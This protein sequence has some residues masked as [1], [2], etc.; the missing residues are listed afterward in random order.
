[1][2]QEHWDVQTPNGCEDNILSIGKDSGAKHKR[3]KLEKTVLIFRPGFYFSKKERQ[4]LFVWLK[5]IPSVVDI[6]ECEGKVF[7]DF[8]KGKP[9]EEDLFDLSALFYRYKIDIDSFNDFLNSIEKGWQFRK[10]GK[11]NHYNVW[12]GGEKKPDFLGEGNTLI[13]KK[14][15]YYSKID[16]DIFFEWLEQIPSVEE[17][18]GISDQLFVNTKSNTIPDEDLKEL[19]TLFY[20]YGVD[21]KQLKVFLND[22]NKEWFFDDKEAFWHKRVFGN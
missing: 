2:R 10:D 3:S 16:E 15:W 13:C 14:I 7:V 11:P 22:K 4:A 6:S 8:K 9:T 17:I 5:R 19:I 21:M 1:M 18:K 20:R 12:P